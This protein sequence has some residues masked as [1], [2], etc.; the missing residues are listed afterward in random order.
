[1]NKEYDG[2]VV[3]GGRFIFRVHKD[4]SVEMID[5]YGEFESIILP[6]RLGCY[7]S[8]LMW[9]HHTMKQDKKNM[10]AKLSALIELVEK[11]DLDKDVLI[12]CINNCGVG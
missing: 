1:M 2:M 5:D 12:A 6:F 7:L 8:E 9:E 11:T 3:D 4:E 10:F